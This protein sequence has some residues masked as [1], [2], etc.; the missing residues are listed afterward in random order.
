VRAA[1]IEWAHNQEDLHIEEVEATIQDLLDS[2]GV[3]LSNSLQQLVWVEHIEDH[4]FKEPTQFEGL[5]E[6][7]YREIPYTV[8]ASE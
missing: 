4:S 8:I 2:D 6:R 1:L 3:V 7:F 5:K